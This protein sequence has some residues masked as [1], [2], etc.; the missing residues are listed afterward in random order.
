MFAFS[1][2]CS[3]RLASKT[4]SY[5]QVLHVTLTYCFAFEVP[6]DFFPLRLPA[7]FSRALAVITHYLNRFESQ[8]FP[9]PP[10]PPPLFTCS[11]E[12]PKLSSPSVEWQIKIFFANPTCLPFGRP[13]SFP[14]VF[15]N[16]IG[17]IDFYRCSFDPP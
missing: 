5:D 10:V 12:L 7:S 13:R 14:L 11:V 3:R 2:E 9:R 6:C 8:R 1:P 17:F 4:G 16:E 15:L